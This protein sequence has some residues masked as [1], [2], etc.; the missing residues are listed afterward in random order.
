MLLYQLLVGAT[1]ASA[2][3]R[4]AEMER[5]D[6]CIVAGIVDVQVVYQESEQMIALNYR[7]SWVA[8]GDAV[9]YRN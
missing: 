1:P 3:E 7:A 9:V 5:S 2:D 6:N 8:R 4:R